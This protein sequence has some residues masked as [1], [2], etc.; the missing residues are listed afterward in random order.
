MLSFVMP[1]LLCAAFDGR[2]EHSSFQDTV[3]LRF[4][5]LVVALAGAA[6]LSAGGCRSCSSCHDYDPPVA[7][8]QCS[9][10]G[11][12]CGCTGCGGCNTGGS[13]GNCGCSSCNS[14]GGACTGSGCCGCNS[15]TPTHEG[16]ANCGNGGGQPINNAPAY[17]QKSQL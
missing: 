15:G 12:P 10:C 11:E 7:N 5:F 13:C 8:C 9:S 4:S 14:A 17:V 1:H 3:M 2:D 6:G 16:C